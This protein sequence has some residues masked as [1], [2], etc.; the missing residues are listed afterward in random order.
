[1]TEDSGQVDDD[2]AKDEEG[3]LQPDEVE[4]AWKEVKDETLRATMGTDDARTM[5][6]RQQVD[7]AI[8]NYISDL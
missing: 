7:P 4:Q 3:E 1:M 6:L 5:E 8:S 2:D